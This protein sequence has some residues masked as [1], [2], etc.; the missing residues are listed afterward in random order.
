MR[1]SHVPCYKTIKILKIL[2]PPPAPIK[3]SPV[4]TVDPNKPSHISFDFPT[5]L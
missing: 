2:A 3:Y 1:N 5:H 4:F